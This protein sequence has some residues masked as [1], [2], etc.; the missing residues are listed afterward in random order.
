[1]LCPDGVLWDIGNPWWPADPSRPADP[2]RW[3][4]RLAPARCGVYAVD[5]V[6]AETDCGEEFRCA[7]AVTYDMALEG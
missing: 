1:M 6:D 4:D 5:A 2:L 3:G 7:P